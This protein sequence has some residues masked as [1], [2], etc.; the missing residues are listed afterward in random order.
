MYLHYLP[1][2]YFICSLLSKLY[3]PVDGF[4]SEKSMFTLNVKLMSLLSQYFTF[5]RFVR[6]E[7]VYERRMLCLFKLVDSVHQIYRYN[8]LLPL[9]AEHVTI[10]LFLSFVWTWNRLSIL[11]CVR[12]TNAALASWVETT[13]GLRYYWPPQRKSAL[14][15]REWDK[16]IW[17]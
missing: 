11:S 4:D 17:I 2:C 7:K 3:Y 5:N 15:Y 12:G 13:N 16:S 9:W 10:V 14:A 1:V 8:L 6:C